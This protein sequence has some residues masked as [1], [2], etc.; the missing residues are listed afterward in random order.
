MIVNIVRVGDKL[1]APS[2]DGWTLIEGGSL[3]GSA[4]RYGAL[5]YKVAGASEGARYSFA[6]DTGITRAV[7]AMVAFSG[8]NTDPTPF[9][10]APGPI[11]V[12]AS[13]TD[14][15]ATALTTASAHAAVIMFG[16]AAGTAP[17]WS[18]W[19][20]S[21]P[22][23][24]TELYD[25]QGG[26]K[27]SVGAAWAVK[28]VA[29]DTGAGTATL[30]SAEWNGSILIALKPISD[31]ETVVTSSGTPSTY[32]DAVT[33]TATVTPNTVVIGT[34]VD[35]YNG[36]T[37]LGSGTI[38]GSATKSASFTTIG[39]QLSAG[40]HTNITATFVGDSAYAP[41]TSSAITQTVTPLGITG[42]FT[43][44]DK[45]YD[46]NNTAV[47][48]TRTLNGVLEPDQAEV[49]LT[50]GT[51]SFVDSQAAN[52]KPVTL[53]DATLGG[54]ASGN[55][56][57]TA[58]ETALANITGRELSV[59]SAAVTPKEYDGTTDAVI[60]GATL[61]GV[62]GIDIVTLANPTTGTFNDKNVGLGKAVTGAMT[63]TGADA[64]NYTL[65]QPTLTGDITPAALTITA[66]NKTRF[67]GTANP[68]LTASYKG[69]VN[70][71]TASVLTTPVNLITPADFDSPTGDYPIAASGA[72][73]GNYTITYLDGILTVDAAPQ[74]TEVMHQGEQFRFTFSTLTGQRY[75]VEDTEELVPPSWAP[76]GDPVVGT[77]IPVT[78]THDIIGPQRY[79]RIQPTLA[80]P[81]NNDGRLE[82]AGGTNAITFVT[83][84][85]HPHLEI[86]TANGTLTNIIWHWGDGTFSKGSLLA[87]HDFGAPGLHTNY[88]EVLPRESLTY[89]GAAYR[90]TD[91]GIQ[92]IYG[93]TNFPNLNFLYLYRESITDLSLAGCSN[94][95]QLHLAGNPVSTSVCDQWFIDLDNAVTGPVTGA[96]FWYPKSVRSAASDAAWTNLVS[97]GY[98]MR[99]Y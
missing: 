66:D 78:V 48:L 60:T 71:E 22:G 26:T 13:Q 79:F 94:L 96:D 4:G 64:G 27:T 36:A 63:L 57:L 39:T 77:G 38:A 41:S 42:H 74:L 28:A 70:N 56:S 32:G 61:N 17:T 46:G 33:F 98:I 97:K 86:R 91:Q 58:V 34:T 9:D 53:S 44:E 54:A 99:P 19:S 12:Q 69:F 95:V 16:M 21:S 73:A 31:T 5:L 89:F 23:T 2:C 49:N 11:S 1:T 90:V 81:T 24:L 76:L 83:I 92:G 84:S 8:V 93:L 15:A 43:A 20:T 6:L 37:L 30:S 40:S 68:A 18:G 51:A 59:T 10:I 72:V 7:G 85:R 25:H 75:Q 87:D 52:N 50:G 47:V 82:V 65:N 55:Y 62:L 45:V 35:F 29:G 3:D 14:V 67:Y 80:W 88:V